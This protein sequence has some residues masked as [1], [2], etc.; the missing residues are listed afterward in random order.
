MKLS[1]IKV[2]H[3]TTVDMSLHY[4]LLN[5]LQSLQKEGYEVWG[6][7]APGP[8]VP[9]IKAA[10]IRYLPVTMSRR[11]TPFSDL[12]SFWR[13]YRIL[14]RERFTI[15]HTHTPKPGLLGQLA[16]RLAGVPVVVNTIHGFYFHDHMPPLWRRFYITL[17]KIAAWCSDVILSQNQEDIQ[18]AIKE[19]ICQPEEIKYLGNGFDV[20]RFAQTCLDERHLAQKRRELSLPSDAP[21]V[22]FVGRLVAEKGIV[23]L[24]QAAQLIITQMPQARF[25]FIGPIDDSKPDALT[26]EVAAQYGVDKVCIFTGRRH[27]MPELYA[28]MDVLVLPSHREGFP[29]APMEASF[30]GVPSVVSDIRG[31]REVVEHGQNGWLVPLGDV[32]ALADAILWLLKNP[33]EAKRMG[34]AG[35]RL[36]R[37]RFDERRIFDKV[38]AEYVRLLQGKGLPS[39]PSTHKVVI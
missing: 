10:G 28:L 32:R 8:E 27:D 7:S 20:E 24:L 33:H 31:C 23:E 21:V 14:K 39:P 36:A 22:G 13:L 5:Q 16:A 4:M 38:K 25:L 12:A 30:M 11:F 35:R 15:V 19:G 9:V 37:E 1:P 3:I 17:E 34:E 26:P 29:R 2:V 18:T 6:I